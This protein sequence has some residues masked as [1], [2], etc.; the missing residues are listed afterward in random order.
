MISTSVIEI[1]LAYIICAG[2]IF[3]VAIAW[4]LRELLKK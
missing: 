1:L 4:V 2:L 3:A